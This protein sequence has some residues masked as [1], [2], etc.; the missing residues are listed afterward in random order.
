MRPDKGFT[1]IELMIVLA[2]IAILATVAAPSFRGLILD[3]R[4]SGTSNNI[5]GALQMAR[6]E[7]V[8]LRS[9]IKVCAANT[10]QT[11]CENSTDWSKG[12]LIMRG[13]T[14]LRVIPSA[15][16]DVSVAASLKEIVYQGNGTTHAATV[17]VS[18]SRPAQRVIK[19]NAI[20]QAC[21]GSACS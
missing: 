16:T 9:A 19:V 1:L 6:S 11:A 13:T 14:L 12:V 20:G 7:A 4:L 8:T 3:N 5:L 17:T 15:N 21:S 10:A 18:D 2:I